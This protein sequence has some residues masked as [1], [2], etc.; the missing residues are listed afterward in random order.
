[1]IP[2]D[3]MRSVEEMK[4]LE[5]IAM[6]KTAAKI[7]AKRIAELETALRDVGQA[8]TIDDINDIIEG[9]CL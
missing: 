5:E 8:D 1:M 7:A 3:S 6:L 9:A 4:L 2:K